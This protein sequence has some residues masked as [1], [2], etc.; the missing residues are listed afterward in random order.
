MTPFR[1]SSG[2]LIDRSRPLSFAFDGKALSGFS[3]DS[4][5]S[6]LLAN[7]RLLVGRSFKYHRPRGI[8]TAG[9][10]EPNALMTIG[11]GGRTEPN[12][13]ATMQELYDGLEASSQ[14]RWPSLDFD[15]GAFNSLLSPFLSAG[16]YYKT[17]MWPAALWEKLYEPFI[18]RAAGLGRASYEADPDGY[19]KAWIH[20]DLL[21]VGAGAAGLAAALAAGRAGARVILVDEHSRCGG[22]LLSE[23]VRIGDESATEFVATA[24]AELAS[25]S[26]VTV[27][28]RTTVFGWYDGNVFGAVERVQKHVQAPLE[29]LPVERLW[30]IV[31]R[32]ALLA[33]G[34]EERPLVFGGNDI[35]GVMMAGAMRS[36]L[37]RYAVAPGRKVAI[38]TTNDS[39]YALARDLE[40]VGASDVVIIDSRAEGAGFRYA[41]TA[42]IIKGAVVSDAHGG[43]SLSSISVT[44]A[45]RTQKLAVDALA[46]S[47]GFNPVISLACHRG[48]RPEWNASSSVFLAPSNLK[49]LTLTGAAANIDGLGACL[50]HGFAKGAERAEALGY[51]AK[52]TTVP[53]VAD[54]PSAVA[55]PLWSI[56]GVRGKAFVDYQND[57][58][59]KDLGLA[60]RE[61]YGHVELAKRYTTNGMATD[62]GKLSNVNAIAVLAQARGVSPAEV[63]TTTFRPFYTP[64][65]FGALT[66]PSHGKHFQPV[67]KSPLHG[68]ASRNGATFV[69]TGLWY[70]SS[71][72]PRDGETTWRESVDR[73]VL[74]V[75]KNAGICDV[76][77]LGKIEI[78]GKDAA[79]FL[80]RVY[81]NAFLKLPVGKARYGLMLRE[82]GMIYDDGTTSRLEENRYF[83]TTTTAYAAGV[84]NHL[85]FCAQALWPDL[86]VRLASVTDQ[87]AQM[88]VA[89][90][91]SRQILQAIVDTDISNEAFPFL[92]AA[93]VS[94]FGGQLRGRLF[95]ISFSGELAYE[96]AVPAG[97][98]D[99]VADAIM[100]AGA[101]HGIQPYG[102]ESLSVL[103]IEKGHVT[104]NEINGTVVPKDLG[105]ARMVSAAKADFIGKRMLEREGLH[106]PDRP[107][108]VGIVPLDPAAGFRTGSHILAKN[109]APTLEND[110]GYVTSTCYSPHVGSTI[111]LALVRRGPERHGEEIMIWNGLRGEFTPGRICDPVSFDA[112]NE[113]LH[114]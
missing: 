95:R 96:L 36:Y 11:R 67:R 59:R 111:G 13:R 54:D 50:Q 1:L 79:E 62:Q 6:A 113:K 34:A 82:D 45:G 89:G 61:G 114:A 8:L 76:S 83:M 55:K 78:T 94:L 85:E 72:F 46:M 80:N 22:G 90:P 69:E 75:R 43:K 52:R 70:R 106:A 81:C 74:N 107:Q 4:L 65:S 17:F 30:R 73:E 63:G 88:A 109:A 98:G 40:A 87:W 37:N 105:F 15:I 14:N 112:A 23:T 53:A 68:W 19:E 10:A 93:E 26:N 7:G 101:A 47:G 48:G 35:P 91:K 103:R 97:Y 2:G 66:G 86:D 49:G 84:M 32:E 24:L 16:F 58:H 27:M 42:K 28:P 64:V 77:M 38:F 18:R 41:G 20:C 12:T 25:L 71:W 60:V 99:S 110:Q 100:Q 21:V 31:A 44:I 5:A 56:P 108:L 92:G 102:V 104:H 3:G 9:S 33:T 29:R 39:G 51:S 57:V